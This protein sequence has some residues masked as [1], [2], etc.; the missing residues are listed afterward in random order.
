LQRVSH[1]L[2]PVERK[3]WLLR[4]RRV[5]RELPLTR[6]ERG[7]HHVGREEIDM[8]VTIDVGEI[9]RHARV[10]RLSYRQRRRQPEIPA[11][12]I[13]PDLIWILEVIADVQVGRAVTIHVVEP[14][15]QAE[16]VRFLGKR[17]P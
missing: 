5:G 8:A 15:R 9:H 4:K 2:L 11:S 17:L 10:A 6:R 14:C 1:P 12:V 13:D 16:V 3:A 7:A